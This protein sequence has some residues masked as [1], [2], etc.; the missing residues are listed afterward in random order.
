MKTKM[1][2][3]PSR[4]LG[5]LMA[6]HEW[7]AERFEENRS[8][9]QAVVYRMLGSLSEADNAVQEAWIRLSRSDA[10]SIENLRGWFTT[11][12]AW[13][14]LARASVASRLPWRF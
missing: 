11:V 8:H 5:A 9:L 12:V 3:P 10:S 13:L 14:C 1:L 6:E 7:L 2:R 4:T